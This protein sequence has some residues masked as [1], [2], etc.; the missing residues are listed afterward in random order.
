MAKC[1]TCR[2]DY[3]RKRTDIEPTATSEDAV[4]TMET[5]MN[6]IHTITLDRGNQ[7]SSISLNDIELNRLKEALK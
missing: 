4:I 7:I 2:K 1:M 3:V 6:R 5:N